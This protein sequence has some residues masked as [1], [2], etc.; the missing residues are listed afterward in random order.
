[1]NYYRYTLQ[2][3]K[4][5]NTR[6][7]CPKCRKKHVF[8]RYIDNESNEF[9]DSTVGRCGREVKCGY[10]Y[11]PKQ[12]FID[13]ESFLTMPSVFVNRTVE[14]IPKK[15][16]YISDSL[17]DKSRNTKCSNNLIIYLKSLFGDEI[18]KQ[19]V[20][21]YKIGTSK[22]WSGATVF[23]QIDSFGKVRAGK[24]IQ[25]NE[26]TGKR[27]KKPY[28]HITWVHSVLKLNDFNLKQCFFGEHL[29]LNNNKPIAIVESEKSAVIASVYFPNFIWIAA[30]SL[31]NF[32]V[33][34][35]EVFK[36]RNVILF[37]DVNA[38]EKWKLIAKLIS[39]VASNVAV[40]DYLEKHAS[41]ED[42]VEGSDIADYISKFCLDKFK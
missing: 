35:C 41:D 10:H 24:I 21:K 4:G 27:I 20:L 40:S 11:T 17:V 18:V 25:Y 31:L 39:N 7:E 33:Q 30:G 2:L 3:Y 16:S 15:I 8:T 29:I 34:K 26:S 32:S 37:P 38:Y 5:L 6:Y 12:F 23:W 36:N 9:L 13:N 28:N 1:M 22:H 19:L 14:V 42:R